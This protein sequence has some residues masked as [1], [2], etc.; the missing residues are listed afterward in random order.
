MQRQLTFG[1]L[2]LVLAACATSTSTLTPVATTAGDVPM[3]IN[4][5]SSAF[6][7]GQPIPKLYTCD[8]ENSSVPL[9][10]NGVPT[11]AI[12]LALIMDD[13]DA[14]NGTFVHWVLYNVPPSAASI[15]ADM[16]SVATLP[17]GSRNGLNSSHR[18]GYLGP[19]PP[20]GTHRYF[21]KLYA[22]D[23]ILTLEP[24]ATKEQ[25][26]TAMKGHILAQGELMGTYKH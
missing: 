14:P 22:L 12:S 23:M 24:G 13:P 15:S 3:S 8:G 2:V 6:T 16:S 7:N 9:A 17:D 11:A 21:I 19:C 10:W 25:L 18:S 20:S 1:L 26:L 5:T 4:I